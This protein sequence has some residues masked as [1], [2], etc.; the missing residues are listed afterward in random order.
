MKYQQ[1]P[2]IK[3]IPDTITITATYIVASLFSAGF[4]II[5]FKLFFNLVTGGKVEL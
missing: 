4:W 3:H 1:A 2:L 5:I